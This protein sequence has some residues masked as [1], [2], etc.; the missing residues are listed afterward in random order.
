M[1]KKSLEKTHE[2]G[3]NEGAAEKELP[4]SRRKETNSVGRMTAKK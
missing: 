4:K 1:V 2:W 3:A